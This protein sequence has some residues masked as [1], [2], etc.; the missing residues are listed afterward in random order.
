MAWRA[1][2]VVVALA[3]LAQPCAGSIAMARVWDSSQWHWERGVQHEVGARGT[4]HT[5]THARTHACMH[6]CMH[7][8]THAR[9]M[10]A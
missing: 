5:G 3:A 1:G 10:C 4:Q 8:R 6:A 2:A 9:I 7:A